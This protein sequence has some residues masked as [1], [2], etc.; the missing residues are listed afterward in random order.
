M[1]NFADDVWRFD[2]DFY[3]LTFDFDVFYKRGMSISSSSPGNQEQ[4][5]DGYLLI[6]NR[7]LSRMQQWL[8][9]K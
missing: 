2:V 4:R 8:E 3:V 1:N 5:G 6:L 7:D 9:P